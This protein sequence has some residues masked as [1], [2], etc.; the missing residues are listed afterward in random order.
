MAVA[1][2]IPVI[3]ICQREYMSDF[4]ADPYAKFRLQYR[5]ASY[6]ASTIALTYGITKRCD[7]SS[8]LQRKG[9]K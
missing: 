9:T 4:E 1:R 3:L 7:T 6:N 8:R 2:L 5:P